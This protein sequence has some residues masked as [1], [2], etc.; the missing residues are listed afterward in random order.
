MPGALRARR[1][2][3]TGRESG[4]V[5]GI[6]ALV[7]LWRALP[8]AKAARYEVDPDAIRTKDFQEALRRAAHHHCGRG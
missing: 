3:R 5:Q 4:S 2:C 8:L 6:S 7:E 1:P